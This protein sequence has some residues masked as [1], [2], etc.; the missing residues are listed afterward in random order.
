MDPDPEDGTPPDALCPEHRADLQRSGLTD[1]TIT[2]SG[3]RS[4]PPTD[5]ARVL[6]PR[7]ASVI[8]SAM[9]IPYPNADGFAR[10]KLFPPVR[11]SD[12]KTMRYYQAPESMVRLY[13][14]SRAHAALADPAIP[15]VWTEGEKKGLAGDQVGLA[16]LALGGLWNWLQDGRP[17]TDLGRIDHVG[18]SELLVPDSEVWTRPDGLQP[19]YALG[20][21]LDSRGA[22][23]VVVKLSAG[24]DGGK[25]GLDDYLMSHSSEDFQAL[26]RLTLKDAPL[27]RLASWYK[28]WA[29]RKTSDT[30]SQDALA[31]LERG[32][33]VR[34]LHPAQDVADGVLWYGVPVGDALVLVNSNRLACT[35][36]T[37]PRGLALRHVTLRESTVSRPVAL[38][39]AAG[40]SGSVAETLDALATFVRT[41]VVVP[42]PRIA[43]LLAAWTLGTYCYRA[44]PIFPYLP[45]RSPEKRCGK[46]RLLKVL[47]LVAFNAGPLTAVPT[48]AQL[49]RGAASTGGAQFFDEMEGLRGDKE[50]YDALIAVLNVGFEQEG[51]V[52]RHEKR[53]DQWVEQH[54][55]VYAPRALAGIAA[56]K[57][58][59]ADRGLP[60]FMTRK[61]LEE[62]VG[63]LSAART[64]AGALRDCCALACL[65]RIEDILAA[66]EHAAGVLEH[67]RVDDRATD[68]WTPLVALALVADAEDNGTRTK[69]L[70]ELAVKF[71]GL[72]DA[73]QDEGQTARLVEALLAIRATQTAEP[74]ELAPETLRAAL[75]DRPG[76]DWVKTTKRLAGLLNPLGFVN[77]QRRRPDGKRGWAYDLDSERLKDL[78]ARY[79]GHGEADE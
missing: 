39:W 58:T 62:K 27:A 40:A 10:L 23:V 5:F 50:R 59:L 74:V 53:G 9:L 68:L 13:L 14:P 78:S 32:D 30:A 47:R 45:I 37:L 12:G 2:A 69:T 65:T 31:L 71:G 42:D 60:V 17:I 21:E 6:G 51:V 72:R 54:Y 1:A 64:A 3:I 56:L 77:T 36:T 73:E 70:L 79:G 41:Y 61:R 57:D 38:E 11:T 7:L 49:F 22:R 26:P 44:F 46:T 16:C 43:G 76:W 35:A 24:P 20:R 33:P 66:A 67:E 29:A 34:P 48:E 52:T 4:V 15:L 63:R 28:R 25:C 55:E 19:V 75:A 8:T 18:R